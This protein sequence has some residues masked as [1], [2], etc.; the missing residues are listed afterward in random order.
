VIY[1][2]GEYKK[3]Y[4]K[5]DD[6]G[7]CDGWLPSSLEASPEEAINF[8]RATRLNDYSK[9][10]ANALRLEINKCLLGQS[11]TVH[12]EDPQLAQELLRIA[13]ET[14]YPVKQTPGSSHPTSSV[15]TLDLM[16]DFG[17]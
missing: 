6:G 11:T 9:V 15:E 16:M 13:A 14:D 7:R 12:V 2:K 3:D 4:Y 1:H 10:L 8:I 17:E 5:A